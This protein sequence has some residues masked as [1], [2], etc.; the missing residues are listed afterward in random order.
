LLNE[1]RQVL[2]RGSQSRG[3][4]FRRDAGRYVFGFD[5]YTCAVVEWLQRPRHQHGA[6]KRRVTRFEF[7]ALDHA[8][9]RHQ[10]DECAFRHVL[11]VRGFASARTVAIVKLEPI[12][13]TFTKLEF[14]DAA[15]HTGWGEPLLPGP[16]ISEGGPHRLR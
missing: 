13:A 7:N 2:Q 6:R 4:I 8:L 3:M 14:L 5:R 15:G 10:F 9:I 12:A 11:I 1:T 16:L